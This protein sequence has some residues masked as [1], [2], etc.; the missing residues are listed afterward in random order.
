MSAKTCAVVI[1]SHNRRDDLRATCQQL[2]KL[3]PA[4][5]EI[6]ICLDG[7]TDGS[8][9]MLSREF[10]NY[11]VIENAIQE[12]SIPSRDRAFRMVQSDL[13]L[14]LDD[15]S[16]PTDPAF[17][18]K[19]GVIVE[20]H[21]EAGAI[22]FPEI[23]NVG[24]AANPSLSSTSRG[25]YVRE[26]P[27]CAGVIGRPIYG[28][29][30]VY[31]LFFSHAYGESDFCLQLYAA[32]YAV[33]FEP[34]LTI[35]HRYTPKE[36]NMMTRHWLNARNEF[37]SVIM[38]CPFPDIAFWVPFRVLRQFMFAVSKGFSWWIREPIWWW[39][40]IR[41]IPTCFRYRRPVRRRAYREWLLLTRRPAFDL[42]DLRKRFHQRFEHASA[43][44]HFIGATD[45]RIG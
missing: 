41:G 14:T 2:E 13:I 26:F 25:R 8:K 42:E 6:I 38:R 40:A 39:R 45:A 17:I 11:C 23:R 9:E 30:A 32:G 7:C 15:D 4:P 37:W 43:G 5:D 27:D 3:S 44:N 19:I 31:P 28:R 18:E 24:R 29:A 34:S 10:P 21:P 16:Y 36:R 20:G 22:T 33:W 35:R 12:G 1:P